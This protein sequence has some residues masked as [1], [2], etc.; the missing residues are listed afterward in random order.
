MNSQNTDKQTG[1]ESHEHVFRNVGRWN[2]VVKSSVENTTVFYTDLGLSFDCASD[3]GVMEKCT[4][5]ALLEYRQDDLFHI[6]GIKID[7]QVVGSDM[8]G[9]TRNPPGH[10]CDIQFSWNHS[11]GFGEIGERVCKNAVEALIDQARPFMHSL[12]K[13]HLEE[14]SET[15]AQ[16]RGKADAQ[17]MSPV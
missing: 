6:S 11:D 13:S 14:E 16:T 5:S 15:K 3:N 7:G 1:A 10:F 17:Q 8:I 9:D 2:R 4:V 12:N